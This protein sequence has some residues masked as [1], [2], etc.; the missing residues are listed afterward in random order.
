MLKAVEEYEGVHVNV[1]HPKGRP[2]EPRLVEERFGKMQGVQFHEDG[3]YGDFVYNPKHPIAEQFLW[4]AEHS[5][6]SV[7]FSHNV[8]AKTT[9]KK[10]KTVVEE[11]TR[12]QSV[13]VVADPAT[14]RGL[15]ESKTNTSELE[16]MTM[17][18]ALA[19][20]TV[21]DKGR[22]RHGRDCQAAK[23]G[24]GTGQGRRRKS[25]GIRSEGGRS[26]EEDGDRRRAEGCWPWR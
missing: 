10:G 4:N 20:A 18:E 25:K 19:E 17:A 5:P 1:N 26:R 7:G 9:R 2:D 22:R 23:G 11:I 12:V 24:R 16:G 13:D 6:D 15:F 3:L 21:D 14:T 8:Q